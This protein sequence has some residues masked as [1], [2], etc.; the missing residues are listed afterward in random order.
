MC[1]NCFHYR[2]NCPLM[3]NYKEIDSCD[4]RPHSS[5]AMYVINMISY[6]LIWTVCL[7]T[8]Y[9]DVIRVK[10]VVHEV[11]HPQREVHGTAA[12][13]WRHT[14]RQRQPVAFILTH[15]GS[16]MAVTSPK[17]PCR[18]DQT[19]T[20][21]TSVWL[22]FLLAGWLTDCPPTVWNFL[23]LL[24]IHTSTLSHSA[25]EHAE[26]PGVCFFLFSILD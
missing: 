14:G 19:M 16:V 2:I 8:V 12:G 4:F 22:L 7:Q 21:L 10:T 5:H 25:T 15:F 13:L 6:S 11:R 3:G 20:G 17:S 24:F 26:I 1:L 9:F 18:C 23:Y